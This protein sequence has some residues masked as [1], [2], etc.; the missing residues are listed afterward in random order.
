M[1]SSFMHVPH[2][3]ATWMDIWGPSRLILQQC[4][5]HKN[6]GIVTN[7]G[8]NEKLDLA[9]YSK[10]SLF[11][12]ARRLRDSSRATTNVAEVEFLQLL[13][14]L[15]APGSSHRPNLLTATAAEGDESGEVEE[16]ATTA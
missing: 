1:A 3:R 16:A 12:S 6:G 10:R 11:A 8:V 2:E 15:P 13:G 4:T 7:I 14:V 5:K 9:I